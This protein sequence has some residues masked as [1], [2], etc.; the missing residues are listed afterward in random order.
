MNI[1]DH[2]IPN[3]EIAIVECNL[4][5]FHINQQI[6][7][8]GL[9]DLHY[10]CFRFIFQKKIHHV[11]FYQEIQMQQQECFICSRRFFVAWYNIK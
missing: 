10:F 7:L 5:F 3:I 2:C 11:E 6:T 1:E 4:I 9:L 8:W